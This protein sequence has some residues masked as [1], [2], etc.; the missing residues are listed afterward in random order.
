MIVLKT[1]QKEARSSKWAFL[2]Y[3]ESAPEDYIERLDGKHVPYIISPLHNLDVNS[4]TGE[5]KKAHWHGCLFFESLKSQSQVYELLSDLNGPKYVEVVHSPKGMY[6]Y[7]VHAENPDKTPY[8]VEDI[9]SGCG[10]NL[11]KFL[12]EQDEDEFISK[13]IDLIEENDFI[14]FRQLVFYARKE[15]MQLLKLII[16]R[17]YFFVK[18]L[19]SRRNAE[20][21]NEK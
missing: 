19:D 1:K 10:F 5:L 16:S 4:E 20:R 9:I 8:E 18:Y 3:E 17:A 6:D 13:I 21:D 14:E 7:F 11:G 2:I 12:S 15:N